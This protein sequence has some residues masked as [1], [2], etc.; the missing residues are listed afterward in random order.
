MPMY[1]YG[2]KSCNGSFDRLRR[3]EQRDDDLACPHC[4]DARVQ[5]KLSVFAAFSKVVE[6]AQTASTSVGGGGCCGG[7]GGCACGSNN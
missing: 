7:A 1:E 2:C 4:G 3:M 5:R 6:G